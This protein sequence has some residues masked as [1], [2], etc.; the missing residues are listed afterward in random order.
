VIQ[1]GSAFNGHMFLQFALGCFAAA[2]LIRQLQFN[3]FK[4]TWWV[5]PAAGLVLGAAAEL[6]DTL[7]QATNQG[8]LVLLELQARLLISALLL[9]SLN[10]LFKGRDRELLELLITVP[11]ILFLQF[12][13]KPVLPVDWPLASLGGHL[14]A[15]LVL[16][17]IVAILTGAQEKYR[18]NLAPGSMEGLPFRL[19]MLLVL[20]ILIMGVN[21]LYCG[22]LP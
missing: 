19:M 8:W 20:T 9:I 13:L 14:L 3:Q 11:A 12:Q 21:S 17:L 4:R 18:R 5:Y 1:I 16:M 15:G 10:R 22:N 2:L 7:I 6:C